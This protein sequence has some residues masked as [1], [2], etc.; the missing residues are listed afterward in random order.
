MGSSS[1][2]QP[3]IMDI[4]SIRFVYAGFS[5]DACG[6]LQDSIFV[7]K[8]EQR[9]ELSEEEEITADELVSE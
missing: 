9:R 4:N 6:C 8:E 7:T 3:Q 5:E 1:G 2:A